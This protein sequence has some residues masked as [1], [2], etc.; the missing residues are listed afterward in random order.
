VSNLYTGIILSAMG[1]DFMPR[2]SKVIDDK[3]QAV[4]LINEQII[5]G[6]VV[7][8][9]FISAIL[10]FSKEMLYILYAKEFEAAAVIVRWHIVG[11]FLRVV[12]FPFSYT[13]LANGKAVHY[14]V[15]QIVFW[16]GD[17]FL[18]VLCSNLFGF[19]GLGVNYPVAYLGY[20]AMTFCV[21]R[22]ICGFA[23]SKEAWRVFAV[24]CFAVGMAWGWNSVETGNV[25]LRWG[26][27]TLVL[28][29][30]CLYVDR[31]LRRKMGLNLWLLVKRKLGKR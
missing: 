15:A 4:R 21:S 2:L 18:L 20:L 6:V 12:A 8:S 19:D 23:F 13:L 16:V 28:G 30:H 5:F 3:A 9:V 22:K 17:F 14:A 29:C 1:V 31:Y 27:G 11:V 25:W 10:L 7:S 24:L 26:G